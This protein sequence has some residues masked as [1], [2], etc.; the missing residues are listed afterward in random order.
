MFAW[1]ADPAAAREALAGGRAEALWMDQYRAFVRLASA[2]AAYGGLLRD[3][4]CPTNRPALVHCATGKDRTGWIVAVL[5]LRLD[6][7]EDAVMAHYL[8]SREHLAPLLERMLAGLAERGGDPELFRPVLDV[9]PGYLEAGLEE[10][11]AMYG[12]IEAY[13][14]D[15]L[16]VDEETLQALREAFLS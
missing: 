16:G 4:A 13:V 2:R 14:S 7:P 8:E 12:S 15:G 9:R 10:V 3:L 11:R 5:Q 6:V 1:A